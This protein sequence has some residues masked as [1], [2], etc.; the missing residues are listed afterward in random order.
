M[1]LENNIAV[2]SLLYEAKKHL[3]KVQNSLT[4]NERV[5]HLKEDF[6]VKKTIY[7]IYSQ[8]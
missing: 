4:D 8:Q 7:N 1:Q 2:E 3:K 6:Q 5:M